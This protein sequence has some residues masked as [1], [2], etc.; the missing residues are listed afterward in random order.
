MSVKII[1]IIQARMGSTRL[2]GK[3]MKDLGGE[4]VLARVV[5]RVRR[6]SEI[7]EI[8]IA[9]TRLSEDDAIVEECRRLSVQVSRGEVSDV[10]DRYYEAAKEAKAEAVV[11]ITSDCTLIETEIMGGTI[12]DFIE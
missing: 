11:R 8:V 7:A 12:R 5:N 3:V 2:P 9:T 1:T 10:L 4:T 6:S